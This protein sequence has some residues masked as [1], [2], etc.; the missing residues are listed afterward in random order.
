[1]LAMGVSMHGQTGL[2]TV[3][4]NA[5]I[6]G[7][8]F[9]DHVLKPLFKKAEEIEALEPEFKKLTDEQLCHKTDEFKA[10]YKAGETLDQLLPGAF[11]PKNL[12]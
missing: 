4:S 3:P 10:R 12:G 2:Y 9:I 11:G 7:Q 5:K 8:V 6:N 1:M